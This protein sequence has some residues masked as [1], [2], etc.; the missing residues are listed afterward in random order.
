MS[1]IRLGRQGILDNG[2]VASSNTLIEEIR[3]SNVP[4]ECKVGDTALEGRHLVKL[5]NYSSY[6]IYWSF[7]E[8]MV[9]G[10]GQIL[11]SGDIDVIDVKPYSGTKIY[12]IAKIDDVA[13]F[14]T[15]VISWA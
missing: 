13:L 14:V 9:Y 15:E 7:N 1:E 4:T 12:A 11:R 2:K 6:Y 5:K 10:E 8:N 3:I